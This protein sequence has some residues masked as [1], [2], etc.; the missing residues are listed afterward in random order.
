MVDHVDDIATGQ[1]VKAV[2]LLL[3]ALVCFDFMAMFIRLLSVR[4]SPQELSAYR[5][6]LGVIPSLLLLV[7]TG[8][9]RL[10]GSKLAIPRP[11]LAILRGLA[12]AL[13]QLFFYAAVTRM[14]LVTVIALNQTQGLFVVAL[15]AL[16]LRETVGPWRIFAV[17]FGFAG[18]LLILRPGSEGFSAYALLPVAA[19]L[20]YGFSM[21]TIRLFPSEVSNGLLYLYSSVAAAVG[22]IAIAAVFTEMSPLASWLDAVKIFAMSMLGGGGVLLMML[23]YRL[24]PPSM[25]APFLYFQLLSSFIL[26][27]VAFGEAPLDTLFPGVFLI[28]GAGALILWRE[29]VAQVQRRADYGVK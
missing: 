3:A 27:W 13:A 4:Y 29:R 14:E 15:S 2:L 1:L 22:A 23:A 11:G 19:A 21:V 18:T 8:E 25:L 24:A 28:V 7:A 16:L 6:V 5:N 20:C 12:V 9:L 10:R 26:G 17:L